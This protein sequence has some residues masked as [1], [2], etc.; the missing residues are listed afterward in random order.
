MTT[1]TTTTSITITT[2]R[3]IILIDV[4][5]QPVDLL[6]YKYSWTVLHRSTVINPGS[7]THTHTQRERENGAVGLTKMF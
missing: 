1:I 2:N 5:Q 4:V 7:H 6:A 3:V